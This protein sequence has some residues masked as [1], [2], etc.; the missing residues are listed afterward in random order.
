MQESIKFK[1]IID[2]RL[3]KFLMLY[4]SPSQSHGE[5]ES[6]LNNFESTLE[7]IPQNN[8][9]LVVALGDF[10]AKSMNWDVNDK[11]SLEGL[12]ID[13]LTSRFGLYW[14]GLDWYS[15]FHVN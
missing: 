2:D 9:F 10:K 11:T 4:R 15:L 8:P 14:I 3:C 5:F 7:V 6:F 13:S 1:L 12:Q